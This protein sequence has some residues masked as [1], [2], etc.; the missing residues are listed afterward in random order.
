[1]ILPLALLVQSLPDGPGKDTVQDVCT[2]CH[3]VERIAAQNHTEEA[4]RN[5]LREMNENGAAFSAEDARAIVAYLT[6][7]FGPKKVNVNQATAKELEA[8]LK[9]TPAE[10]AM[11]L[12]Y[13][14]ENGKIQDLAALRKIKPLE[15]KIESAKDL[16]EF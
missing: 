5:I 6:K 10:A 11:I 9:L 4:W 15:Q 1:M 8:A 7:N 14:V 3:T 2:E 13:R 12:K 16:I